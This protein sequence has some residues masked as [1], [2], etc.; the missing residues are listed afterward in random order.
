LKVIEDRPAVERGLNVPDKF[1]LRERMKSKE[2]AEDYA[3]K[4]SNW[5]MQGMKEDSEKHK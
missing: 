4:S 3:K 1:E 5:I 2:S